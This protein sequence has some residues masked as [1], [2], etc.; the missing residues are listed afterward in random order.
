[1]SQLRQVIESPSR[2]RAGTLTGAFKGNAKGLLDV[3][4]EVKTRVQD[5]L[6]I[7][8]FPMPQFI[9]I[10]SQSV[11][12]SRLVESIA[13]EC[14][15]FVSGTLGS[16]RPTIL[17]FRNVEGAADS[18][19]Y[20]LDKGTGKWVLRAM[21]EVMKIVG[22]AHESLGSDVSSD[23]VNIRVESANCPDMQIVDLPG[24]RGFAHDAKGRELAEKIVT[25]N[26]TF[27]NDP[28]NTI[29]CVEEAGDAANLS[30][31][32]KVTE[33][34]PTYKR[35]ILVRSK[36]DKYY[37]DLTPGNCNKWLEGFGDLPKNLIKFAISMPHWTEGTTPDKSL[38]EMRKD[39]NKQD[40]DK[41]KSCGAGQQQ[42]ATVGWENFGVYVEQET[43]RMFVAAIGPVLQKLR[44]LQGSM[45]QQEV[46]ISQELEDLDPSQMLSTVRTCGTSFAN[47]LTYIMEGFIRSERNRMTLDEE[48]QQFIEYHKKITGANPDKFDFL[49]LP[50]DEFGQL[51][52]YIEYL[53]KEVKVPAF[54]VA[55]NGG[56]QFRRLMFEVECFLRFSEIGEETKKRDVMQGLG[57]AL[58][59]ITWREVVVKLLNHDAHRPLQRRVKYV[60]ERIK[61]FFMQQKEPIVE[62]M[63]SLKGSPSEK[64][65]SSLY[66]RNAKLLEENQ[67]IRKLVFDTYDDVTARQL[68]HFESLFK[69]TLHATFSNP[70]VFPKNTTDSVSFEDLGEECMLPSFDDSKGRIKNEIQ[71]RTGTERTVMKWIY[72]IPM[73][74]HKLD[75]AVDL[76]QLLVLKVY[77]HIRSQI[78]DQ[79]ELFAEAFFKMPLLRRLEE[80]MM[81]IELSPVDQEGYKVRCAKLKD[82]YSANTSAMKEVKECLAI[83]SN[84]VLKNRSTGS[85][86]V[87]G[88]NEGS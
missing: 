6:G 70:W 22:D 4:S 88:T 42:L 74:A 17:E 40:I 81:K 8:D 36:L 67:T 12:K 59:S 80:D 35:T 87:V 23:P 68:Q 29:L 26:D 48:L 63:M 82:E 56:A 77:S 85:M 60:G 46:S 84:F 79:V 69:N 2:E 78:C 75:E 34:D 83:L 14:F 47:C 32:R 38:A 27:L 64:L 25:L 41:L 13:G 71:S 9:L 15:N 66:C 43:T 65:Y 7:V 3:L 11:G 51:D 76:V 49:T 16:R 58:G 57:V 24:Y 10:G 54:D 72:D 62:F 28:R 50:S 19:W 53:R 86:P 18:K 31:L 55:I 44:D 61:W 5:K 73:E 39:F 52:D 33:Y 1:V 30:S 21:P 37:G 20:V 45:I